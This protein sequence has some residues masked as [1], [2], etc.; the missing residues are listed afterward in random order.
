MM[1]A[2]LFAMTDVPVEK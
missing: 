1:K 2:Q